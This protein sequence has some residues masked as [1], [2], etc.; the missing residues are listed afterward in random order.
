MEVL[1]LICLYLL[2]F[3]TRSLYDISKELD[4]VYEDK[5]KSKGDFKVFDLKEQR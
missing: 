2:G 4:E 3:M 5:T 1:A